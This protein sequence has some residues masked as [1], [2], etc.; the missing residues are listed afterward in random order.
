MSKVLAASSWMLRVSCELRIR[1]QR[2]AHDVERVAVAVLLGVEPRQHL[3][4]L[5]LGLVAAPG[6]GERLQLVD[7]RR[8]CLSL[9]ERI[10]QRDLAQ[11]ALRRRRPVAGGGGEAI[12]RER[13]LRC[14]RRLRRGGRSAPTPPAR[15]RPTAPIV[16]KSLS[17]FAGV[18]EVADLDRGAHRV[19]QR[20]PLQLERQ[21]R[22]AR[23]RRSGRRRAPPAH[24]PWRGQGQRAPQ[25]RVVLVADHADWRGPSA[26]PRRGPA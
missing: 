17:R 11:P 18:G 1:R 13:V 2:H 16:S 5:G 15:A 24:L 6:R 23:L 4:R 10:A 12:G 19:L 20:D 8:A 26:P 22:R 14:G 9:A 21:A 7:V 3:Q 25:R